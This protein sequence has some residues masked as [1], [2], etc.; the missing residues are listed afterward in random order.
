MLLARQV[1]AKAVRWSCWPTSRAGAAAAAAAAAAASAAASPPLSPPRPRLLASPAAADQSTPLSPSSPSS[2]SVVHQAPQQQARRTFTTRDY[3]P[4]PRVG[5]GVVVFRRRRSPRPEILLIRRAKAPCKGEWCFPGGS[6]EL[7]ETVAQCAAREVLE[8]TGVRLSGA[9]TAAQL[10]NLSADDGARGDP[11]LGVGRDAESDAR[12]DW[13]VPF[14]VVD[15]IVYAEDGDG[16]GE[17]GAVDDKNKPRTPQFHFTIVEVAA[18]LEPKDADAALKPSDDADAAG[19]FAL[20]ELRALEG[21]TRGCAALAEQAARRFRVYS[22][23]GE[24]GVV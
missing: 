22:D 1:A 15:S 18:V 19:W 20:D 14:A 21:L 11:D 17:Q 9:S 13:P 4:E 8:E 2:T 10:T 16:G 6:L 23:S 3:P 7:G 5:I 24:D 12:L